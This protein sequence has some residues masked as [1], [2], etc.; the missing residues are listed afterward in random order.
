ME[1]DGSNFAGHWETKGCY[2][3]E[4]GEYAGMIYYGTGGSELDMKET[5]V[6]QK[7][8]P[9]GYDCDLGNMELRS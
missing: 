1:G 8:R 3:Y 5:P 2:A 7:Y 6:S 4:E 9:S